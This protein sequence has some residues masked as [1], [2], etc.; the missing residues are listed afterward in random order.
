MATETERGCL[1]D[2]SKFQLV[3]LLTFLLSVSD[4][5]WCLGLW[6][7]LVLEHSQIKD[8]KTSLAG[9]LTCEYILLSL[10]I[11]TSPV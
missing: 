2:L 8:Q 3:G 4:I 10:G 1:L 7:I 5:Q 9:W 11:L 6:V